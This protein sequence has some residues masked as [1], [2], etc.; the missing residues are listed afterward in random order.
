MWSTKTES[1]DDTVESSDPLDEE[2]PIVLTIKSQW[3]YFTALEK[4]LC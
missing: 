4:V 2:K 3:Q 1:H